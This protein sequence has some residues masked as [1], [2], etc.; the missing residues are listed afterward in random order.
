MGLAEN[1]QEMSSNC[2]FKNLGYIYELY[3]VLSDIEEGT[4]TFGDFVR[5][6]FENEAKIF[7]YFFQELGKVLRFAV[8]GTSVLS[9]K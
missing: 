2:Y 7:G 3:G 4:A 8:F 9:V 5:I 1:L 6:M